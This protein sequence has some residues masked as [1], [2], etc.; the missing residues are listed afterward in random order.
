M[1]GLSSSCKDSGEG[2]VVYG[3]QPDDETE[4]TNR[5][6]PPNKDDTEVSVDKADQQN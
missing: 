5:D 2:S 6:A 4:T 3:V 1:F